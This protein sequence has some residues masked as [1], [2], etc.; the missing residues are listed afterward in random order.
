VDLGRSFARELGLDARM[1]RRLPWLGALRTVGFSG[2][3]SATGLSGSVIF[4]TPAA[5]LRAD[6]LPVAA[7]ADP[8]LVVS[9]PREGVT[10]QRDLGRTAAF[11]LDVSRAADSRSHFERRRRFVER[12]SR[13]DLRRD[14]AGQF[15]GDS[16]LTTTP[17]GR[18][19]WRG[20]VR[21][22]AALAATLRRLQPRLGSLLGA[23]SGERGLEVARV[24]GARD[25]YRLTAA[26]D[27]SC[28]RGLP[29]RE[30][31]LIESDA[32]DA[33]DPAVFG[34]ENGRWM[35]GSDLR[36][37]RRLAAEEL[38]PAPAGFRGSGLFLAR[39]RYGWGGFDK[40]IRSRIDLLAAAWDATPERVRI[41][42][43]LDIP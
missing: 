20:E 27:D 35:A 38:V 41:D 19:A 22:P 9:R 4:N 32:R 1:R 25:M 7:G 12:E 18:W 33:P 6:D 15:S 31:L 16:V 23:A 28:P 2:Q 10:A 37:A 40:P 8:P 43:R 39:P 24:R 17:R 11:L 3:A 13:V 29:R 30:C 21:D 5:Q 34:V 42:G 26:A 14:L 36:A